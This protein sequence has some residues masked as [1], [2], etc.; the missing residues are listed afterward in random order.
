MDVC[1]SSWWG[2]QLWMCQPVWG[3]GRLRSPR[4]P[5]NSLG[6]GGG[7]GLVDPPK[8]QCKKEVCEVRQALQ[9]LLVANASPIV[10]IG[11]L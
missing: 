7:G 2:A 11:F 3:P 1:R 8:V 9:V 4:R 6:Q 10:L 5:E